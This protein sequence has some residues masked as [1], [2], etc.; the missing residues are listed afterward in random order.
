M[1]SAENEVIKNTQRVELIW[2]VRET[3]DKIGI[4]WKRKL[5]EE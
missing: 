2:S 5:R 4:S 3:H 1:K